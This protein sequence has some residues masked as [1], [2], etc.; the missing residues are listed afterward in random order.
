MFTPHPTTAI[1]LPLLFIV[2]L[3]TIVSMPFANPE[4]I[5]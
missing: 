1:V 2:S 4:T 3:W 5:T